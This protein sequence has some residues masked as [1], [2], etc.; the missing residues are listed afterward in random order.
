MLPIVNE[1]TEERKEHRKAIIKQ[2]C[3]R[4]KSC[5]C[6][7]QEQ[8]NKVA[9]VITPASAACA[10]DVTGATVTNFEPPKRI[11]QFQDK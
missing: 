3:P 7:T 2:K 10:G 5:T 9:E 8:G 4:P 1:E 6:Q 11:I